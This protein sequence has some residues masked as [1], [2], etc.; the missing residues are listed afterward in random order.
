M[1][2]SLKNNWS[3][4]Q[5]RDSS[6]ES[7]IPSIHFSKIQNSFSNQIFSFFLVRFNKKKERPSKRDI[8]SELV[9]FFEFF[10]SLPV[11]F[12]SRI[13]WRTLAEK[14][15]LSLLLLFVFSID[16][17]SHWKK[18]EKAREEKKISELFSTK[19]LATFQR[20]ISKTF[21]PLKNKL[22]DCAVIII[23]CFSSWNRFYYYCAWRLWHK[24]IECQIFFVPFLIR[25]ISMNKFTTIERL[26]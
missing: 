8:S 16:E 6:N 14:T 4:F 24:I 9:S 3:F 18:A 13:F 19:T 25:L 22:T 21:R 26:L 15:K 7:S 12:S 2:I 5:P 11:F 10:S 1:I 23:S 20:E 17:C